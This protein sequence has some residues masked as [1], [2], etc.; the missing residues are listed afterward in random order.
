[1]NYI[2][3][4]FNKLIIGRCVAQLFN[5]DAV[6]RSSSCRMEDLTRPLHG[7]CSMGRARK[8]APIHDPI[9]G[10]PIDF[11]FVI[12]TEEPEPADRKL[13]QKMIILFGSQ[14]T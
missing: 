8:W 14:L 3:F 10:E 12:T 4:R 2:K 6:L 13:L 1:M 9:N 5:Q 11:A 7:Q